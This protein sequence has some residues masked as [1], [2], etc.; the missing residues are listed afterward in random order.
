MP[1]TRA[2]WTRFVR[3][4]WMSSQTER[5]RWDA[6]F[7]SAEYAYGTEPNR[8]LQAQQSLLP[9]SG[10]ALCVADGEGRNGVWLARQ[11]L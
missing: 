10:Q 6:R 2:Y 4:A 9:S 1:I 3:E 7:A 5:D 8:F 11:G